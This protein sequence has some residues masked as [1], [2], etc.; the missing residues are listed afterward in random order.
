[1]NRFNIET[2]L[3]TVEGHKSSL[4][5]FAS[6]IGKI[7]GLTESKKVDVGTTYEYYG[8]SKTQRIYSAFQFADAKPG[9]YKLKVKIIDIYGNAS[10]EKEVALRV[11]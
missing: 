10:V 3:S 11:F 9:E 2:I 7:L 8:D 5:K 6:S 4:S 1:M